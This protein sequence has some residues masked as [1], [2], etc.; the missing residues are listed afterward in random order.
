ML[1]GILV[2][3]LLCAFAYSVSLE[4]IN[5]DLL[6]KELNLFVLPLQLLGFFVFFFS[7]LIICFK[8]VS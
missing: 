8:Q 4:R 2:V 3:L 5:I 1:W 7:L 6:I